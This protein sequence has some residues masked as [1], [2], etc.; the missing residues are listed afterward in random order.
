[1]RNLF[2]HA[3]RYFQMNM[4]HFRFLGHEVL[5]RR[6]YGQS[7]AALPLRFE[8]MCAALKESELLL[9]EDARNGTRHTMLGVGA[10]D[11]RKVGAKYKPS[12]AIANFFVNR[13]HHPS[14]GNA[15]CGWVDVYKRLNR[16]SQCNIVLHID[17]LRKLAAQQEATL[18]RLG[19]EKRRA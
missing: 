12:L 4:K 9:E 15:Y 19:L 1:M 10:A 8:D 17:V 2:K 11:F 14:F 5:G 3:K 16:C 7:W 18:K 13:K 6:T